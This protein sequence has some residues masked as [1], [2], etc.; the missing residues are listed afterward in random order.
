M[1]GKA[2][3]DSD[4]ARILARAKREGRALRQDEKAKV[5]GPKLLL[6]KNYED[7]AIDPVGWWV[8]EKLDGVRAYWDG[9][10]FISRQG[11]VFSAPEFFT[12][13]MPKGATLDGELWMGRRKFQDTLSVVKRQGEPERWRGL[14]YVVFDAPDAGGPFEARMKAV[15]SLVERAKNPLVK[16][17]A[18]KKVKSA[19]DLKRLLETV[20]KDGGEGLML[21]EPGS[22]YETKRSSTLLKL[23][24]FRDAE[25]KVVGHEPGE[26][27]NRGKLGAL[28]V[29]INVKG[30][31]RR[32]FKIG[33]GFT[34]AQRKDPP[35]VG[36]FITYRYMDVTE[37]G[38][39]KGASFVAVRDYE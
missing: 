15:E 30:K 8:S 3:P 22:K 19:E 36:A 13:G 32:Q 12:K 1:S 38:I 18:Q 29:E 34:D 21:R 2:D 20:V 7:R 6:A 26:G 31:G 25:A 16:M 4:K 14:R 9:E 23:K 33:T 17:V 35:K 39:P 37:D 10:R 24:V 11:N 28:V 5:N 27:K